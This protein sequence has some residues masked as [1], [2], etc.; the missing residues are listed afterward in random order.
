MGR[1]KVHQFFLKMTKPEELEN[2]LNSLSGEVVAIIPNASGAYYID[3]DFVLVVERQISDT[4]SHLRRKR[5][6]R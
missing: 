6:E 2:F 3:I 4:N 5:N 1:Y